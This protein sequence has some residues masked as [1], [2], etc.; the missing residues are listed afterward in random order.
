LCGYALL[1]S[2]C[3]GLLVVPAVLQNTGSVR[4]NNTFVEGHDNNCTAA[5]LAPQELL[6]CSFWR[7]LTTADFTQNTFTISATAVKGTAWGLNA[8]PVGPE[9]TAQVPNPEVWAQLLS[10]GVAAYVAAVHAAGDD[11]LYTITLV[12]FHLPVLVDS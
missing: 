2:V 10:V 12:S 5:I 11:V 8:L 1:F 4:L 9:V 6:H 3:A 7:P